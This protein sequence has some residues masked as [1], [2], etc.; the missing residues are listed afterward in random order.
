MS[1]LKSLKRN[2]ML[3]GTKIRYKKYEHVLKVW[4]K[5]EMKTMKDYHVMFY[6]Q[7]MCL[8]NLEIIA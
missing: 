7:L 8:N 2:Y 6:C 5:L 3:T 4:N 1:D